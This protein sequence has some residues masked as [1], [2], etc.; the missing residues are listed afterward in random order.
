MYLLGR[1]HV[2]EDDLLS[3]IVEYERLDISRSTRVRQISS[4]KESALQK[5]TTLQ[6]PNN[7]VSIKQEDTKMTIERKDESSRL[8]CYNC[9]SK[10]H[11]SPQCPKPRRQKGACYECGS[12]THQRGS[13]PALK[14]KSDEGK[15]EKSASLMS[16]DVTRDQ[17]PFDEYSAP[18][19]VQCQF[20]VPAEESELCCISVNA[21]VDTGSPISLIKSELVPSK[22]YTTQMVSKNNF[23]GINGAKLNVCGIFDT[24]VIINNDVEMYLKFYVVSNCTMNANAILGRDFLNKPGY[25][26]EFKNN[27]VDIAKLNTGNS[28]ATD[29]NFKEILCIDY[30]DCAI[31][32]NDNKLNVNP[33]M[34]LELR[35]A[36]NELYNVDYISNKNRRDENNNLD[37]DMKIILK[38]EQPISFRPRRLSYS[39]QRNLRVIID[40]LLA[41][42][43]I[44]ESNSPYS[45]P[46]VLVRK[47]FGGYRLCVDYRELNKIT[48]KDNFPT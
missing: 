29:I 40:E 14:R 9:G 5:P 11:L 13:C 18:Y 8:I 41:E 1:N 43:I 10:F 21:V 39:E 37:F 23:Y 22:L 48:I 3:D 47:K 26:I 36:F 20:N 31:K 32:N 35:N 6:C 4:V 16:I 17:D 15:K 27:I 28:D 46:I 12:M 44:R 34:S 7:V 25:K 38:H 30:D 2:D 33:V 19:E 42:G 24:N 45:S